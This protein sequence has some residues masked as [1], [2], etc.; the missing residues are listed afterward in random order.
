MTVCADT[1][2]EIRKG[3]HKHGAKAV[4]LSDPDLKITTQYQLRNEKNISPKGLS[5]LPIPATI[6]V[7]AEGVV[8]WID[9]AEDYQ[10][11]S[12]PEL[13]LAAIEESL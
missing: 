3:K 10:V 11:R 12:R 8:K 5:A 1:P 6:L 13:V 9:Q 2:K 4:M 7:D